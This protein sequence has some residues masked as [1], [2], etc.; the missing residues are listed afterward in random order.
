VGAHREGVE[1]AAA[2]TPAWGT[3]VR[4]PIWTRGHWRGIGGWGR[5]APGWSGG[6][7]LGG[8]GN[9]GARSLLRRRCLKFNIISSWN[10]ESE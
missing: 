1:V 5:C 6:G 2:S 4:R 9:D 10:F 3:A 8:E 7:A